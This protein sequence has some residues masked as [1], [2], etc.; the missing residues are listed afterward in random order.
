MSFSDVILDTLI[1]LR[2]RGLL[3]NACEPI[4]REVYVLLKALSMIQW[5]GGHVGS[6]DEYSSYQHSS[7]H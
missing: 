3:D 7:Y 5:C 6:E 1:R 4:E 2:K